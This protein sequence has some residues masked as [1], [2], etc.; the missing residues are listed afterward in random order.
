MQPNP[1]W[2]ERLYKETFQLERSNQ[3]G[4]I[5]LTARKF[6]HCLKLNE[7]PVYLMSFYSQYYKFMHSNNLNP[8]FQEISIPTPMKVD[9][10]SKGE[11][12]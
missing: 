12:N 11:L 2:T 10:N 3:T 1:I 5:I 9:R 6:A 8:K 7:T 4:K